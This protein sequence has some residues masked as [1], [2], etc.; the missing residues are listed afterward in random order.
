MLIV[1]RRLRLALLLLG[2]A[3]VPV[4]RGDAQRPGITLID[5]A[6]LRAPRLN[7]S[8]GI[9]ASRRHPGILWT[10]NDGGDAPV[11]YTTDSS[12]AD[13]GFVRVRGARNEDWED[14]SVGPCTR[15]AGTCLFI[16]DIGDNGMRRRT[17][18]VYVI[19]E[20]DPPCSPSDTMRIALVQDTLLLRY[21][22]HPHNAEA[23]AIADG[24]LLLIT[25]D[26]SG[27]AVLFRAPLAGNN[28]RLLTRAGALDLRTSAVRGRLV[29][30]AAVSADGRL[31]AVRTYPSIH[32][33]ALRGDLPVPVT[34]GDGL[35]IPVVETQGEAIAFDLQGRLVL[36]SERGDRGHA[37]LTRLRLSGVGP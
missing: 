7:E 8:S 31:L 24:Q 17:V 15:T 27:P 21:P 12:G 3:A 5:T 4:R 34:G 14:L 33:F 36:T 6:V 37:I 16:A 23:M 19:A 11:L 10:H 28:I 30:G 18:A 20:P 9:V 32:L 1:R 13:L 35:R 2:A 29:T 25:K 26:L 22:D